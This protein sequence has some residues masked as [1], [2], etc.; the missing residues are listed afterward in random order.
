[1]EHKYFKCK[2]NEPY[3]MYCDG[4][5]GLCTICGGAEGTLTTDCC[6][7]RI[8]HEEEDRIY[9]QCNLDFRDGE[10]VNKPSYLMA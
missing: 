5:L 6:G 1:M 3:C 4:G 8:T 10:W 2:C 9:K 7:R